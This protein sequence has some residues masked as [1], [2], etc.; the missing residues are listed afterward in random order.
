MTFAICLQLPNFLHFGNMVSIWA[1]FIPQLIF[2]HSIF[3]YLVIMIIF[4]W[5]TDWSSPSVTTDPPNLLNMLIYMFLSPGTVDPREQMYPGQ[6]FVQ[7]VLL[8]LALICVPWMLIAKPYMLWKE[9][10][11]KMESGYRSV[12][13]GQNGEPREEED[14]MLQNEEEGDGHNEETE[15]DHVCAFAS[16]TIF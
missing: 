2:L 3:G 10:K 1:E 16:H 6:P 12:G 13:N 7:Q 9:H 5:C 4:K 8:Y 15:E 11:K 14:H